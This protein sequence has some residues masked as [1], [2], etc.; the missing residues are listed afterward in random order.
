MNQ[1]EA[2]AG[3][4]VWVANAASASARAALPRGALTPPRAAADLLPQ[5]AELAA[6]L[7]DLDHVVIAG[8]SLA[9]RTVA[10][11]LGRPL[12]LLDTAD[13]G[14]VRRALAD[15]LDRTVVVLTGSGDEVEAI[16]RVYTS[17]LREAGLSEAEVARRF[18]TAAPSGGPDLDAAAGDADAG[19][20]AP[21]QSRNVTPSAGSASGGPELDPDAGRDPAGDL[22]ATAPAGDLV[23]TA[24]AG[25][26][27]ATALAGD[28]VAT[29]LAGV[30]V[31]ELLD[32]AEELRAA[33]DRE[34]D[35]PGLALAAALHEAATGGRRTVAL[36]SD[37]TGLV[38][39]GDWVARLLAD[40]TGFVPVVLESP[41]A[42]VAG[43]AD[44]LTVTL[45]GALPPGAV[46]GG[47]VRPDVA[48]NGPLGAQFAVWEFAAAALA[49]TGPAD[50][51]VT[52][53]SLTS[54]ELPEGRPDHGEKPSFVEGA[55]AGY[56][57]SAGSVTEAIGGL[58][59]ATRHDSSL[60]VSA[61]L[62][63][64]ADAALAAI[65]QPLAEIAGRPVAFAWGP[66]YP[67]GGTHLQ[68]TGAATTDLAVPGTPYTFGDLEAARA[69]ADRAALARRGRP[70]TRLHLT[71]RAAGI[72]QLLDAIHALRN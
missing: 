4:A 31:V 39:L 59:L 67:A 37:G 29:A 35:N 24:P 8:P 25:D 38:G 43:G 60:V 61:H 46:P 1:T 64:H 36:V 65:R 30:D 58:L 7:A 19:S 69:A 12:T 21:S 17:A 16:H 3:L 20:G 63:R 32:Q 49:P 50:S 72:N 53:A 33:L 5:L 51:P 9:A 14:P 10:D 26:L 22:V 11:T 13:P 18:V 27:V 68:I 45:G 28:L 47:G 48:V 57:T 42:P 54:S 23:A 34:T 6:E 55:V 70:V 71:D 15:R 62:D 44:V 56:G 40:T 2:A 41:D 52:K 66:S